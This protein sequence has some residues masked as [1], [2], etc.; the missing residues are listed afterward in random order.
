MLK[1]AE[2]EEQRADLT[3]ERFLDFGVR[4]FGCVRLRHGKTPQQRVS[5]GGEAAPIDAA[6]TSQTYREAEEESRQAHDRQRPGTG[7]EV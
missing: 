4:F 7:G 1:P 5:D 6:E 3:G 2:V